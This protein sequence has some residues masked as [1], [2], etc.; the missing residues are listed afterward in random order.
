MS[1]FSPIAEVGERVKM[2]ESAD[3]REWRWMP[4]TDTEGTITG[5][6]RYKQWSTRYG[7][8]L[9]SRDPGIYEMDGVP[10]VKWDG[11]DKDYDNPYDFVAID[12]KAYD[13]RYQRL[14]LG[15]LRSVDFDFRAGRKW[16]RHRYDV[17][18]KLNN[19]VRLG[20]LPDSKFWETDKVNSNYG[21]GTVDEV[22]YSWCIDPSTMQF[23]DER[24]MCYR[25]S[26]DRGGTMYLHDNGDGLEILSR[27]PLFK[28]K[29]GETPTFGDLKEAIAFEF[30][31]NKAEE[32]WNPIS[33]NYV[34]TPEQA[35]DAIKKG[36]VDG[37]KMSNGFF[38]ASSSLHVYKLDNQELGEQV[39]RVTIEG[40]RG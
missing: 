36:T 17:E 27:G 2:L 15:P 39:R 30:G 13:E 10:T 40:W 14:Y 6:H 20:D 25:V 9:Y 34:W 26:L 7:I 8:D 37:M 32:I 12:K 16:A 5:R 3:A 38:G 28:L 31:L 18:D 19:T 29:Q 22:M 33:E 4:P 21:F 24:G 35:L 23:K 11:I 1:Y